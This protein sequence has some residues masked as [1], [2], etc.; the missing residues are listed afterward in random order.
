MVSI[1]LRPIRTWPHF[2]VSRSEAFVAQKTLFTP[3]SSKSVTM[4][5]LCRKELVLG[6]WHLFTSTCLRH[7]LEF[8][9]STAFSE[10][11]GRWVEICYPAHKAKDRC[12]PPS[13][14]ELPMPYSASQTHTPAAG[15]G[16][17]SLRRP[18]FDHIA[19]A[20]LTVGICR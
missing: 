2:F 1:A 20:A 12:F 3:S 10:V 15:R 11:P 6:V 4:G 9:S 18:F 13:I 17:A 8:A 7:G 16:C 19:R 14:S 5:N